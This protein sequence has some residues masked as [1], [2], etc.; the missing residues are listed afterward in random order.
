MKGLYIFFLIVLIVLSACSPKATIYGRVVR[1]AG[2]Q[3]PSPDLAPRE[4]KGFKT[5]VY[6]FEP[7]MA[8]NINGKNGIFSQTGSRE[9]ARI[10][11][12]EDGYFKTRLL[13]GRYSV[14]IAKDSL[15]FYSNIQDG[16][17]F[18]NTYEFTKGKKYNIR[19]LADWDAAY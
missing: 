1:I 7:F 17:G 2:N 19:L 11:S 14:L 5:I 18:V 10:Q 3:M 13:P 6:F 16:N 12:N 4:P 15:L 9:I 8:T